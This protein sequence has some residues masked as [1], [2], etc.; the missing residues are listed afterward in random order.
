MASARTG[1][2]PHAGSEASAQK[3]RS[4]R[5]RGRCVARAIARSG[6][7]PWIR[8]YLVPVGMGAQ[9]RLVQGAEA[10]AGPGGGAA[11]IDAAL[12]TRSSAGHLSHP[13]LCS[14]TLQLAPRALR[15]A[16]CE[17]IGSPSP[18]TP[19]RRPNW[20]RGL[21]SCSPSPRGSPLPF[22]SVREPNTDSCPRRSSR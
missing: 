3:P 17:H 10:R 22:L 2:G 12:A 15:S 21:H 16:W 6:T 20:G 19:I 9:N 14:G 7:R 4:L 13:E 5:A 11:W 8:L 1:L 18:L